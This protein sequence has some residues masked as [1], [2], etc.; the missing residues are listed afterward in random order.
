MAKK[1]S[2]KK[3]KNKDRSR[4]SQPSQPFSDRRL[5]EKQL[6]DVGSLLEGQQFESIEEA[7]AFLSRLIAMGQPIPSPVAETPLEKAQELM[8]EAYEARGAKRARLARKA[9]KL[10]E[11]CADAYVL[12]AEETARSPQEALELYEKGVRA[13]ERVLGS[14]MFEENAG[15]FWGILETRPYMRA[16]AGVA[17]LLSFLDRNDEAIHHLQE[18]LRLNPGDNQGLRY[19]LATLLLMTK[20]DDDLSRLLQKYRDE[21]TAAWRYTAALLKFRQKGGTPLAT[22]RLFQALEV[23]AHVPAYLLGQ[24]RLPSERPAFVGLGDDNEAVEYV[25]ANAGVWIE[26]PGAMDWLARNVGA[27]YEDDDEA[28]FYLDD[29]L[30]DEGFFG[31]DLDVDFI[32]FELDEWLQMLEIPAKEHKAIGRSLRAGVG[33]YSTHYY[34]RLRT[35]FL[36]HFAPKVSFSGP[37]TSSGW[38]S[39][40]SYTSEKIYTP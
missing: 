37:L 10:S 17:S 24:K 29:D 26:T 1:K 35:T 34:G 20:R 27:E 18:M 23:N 3:T 5:L 30:L 14:E 21:P 22:S 7:N 9:L 8:Y 36:L 31:D 19:F 32:P 4:Q 12:L 11:D 6:A 28:D 39:P 16:R 25:I 38:P 13:A 2:N 33:A 40:G 15:H